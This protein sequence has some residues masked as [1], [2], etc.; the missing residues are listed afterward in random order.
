LV[1]RALAWAW[2]PSTSA[3]ATLLRMPRSAL[4]MGGP[5]PALGLIVRRSR[6]SKAL[7]DHIDDRFLLQLAGDRGEHIAHRLDRSALAS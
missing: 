7:L 3:A 4:V 2:R 6:D 5:L 1:A